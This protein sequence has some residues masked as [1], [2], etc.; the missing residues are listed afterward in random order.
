[1]LMRNMRK[2]C[3]VLLSIFFALGMTA[4]EPLHYDVAV[5]VKVVPIFAVDARGN[6]VY[7]LAEDELELFVNGSAVPIADF[8]RYTVDEVRE[9]EGETGTG[10]AEPEPLKQKERVVFI[11]MDSIFNSQ[12]GWRRSKERIRMWR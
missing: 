4:Q 5:T 1:M 9:A 11:I 7:D 2:I 8:Q 10:R 6:P 3:L 12:Y